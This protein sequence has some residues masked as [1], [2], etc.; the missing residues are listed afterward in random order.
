[1]GIGCQQS[2]YLVREKLPPKIVQEENP[3]DKYALLVCALSDCNTKYNSAIDLIDRDCDSLALFRMYEVLINNGFPD[4]YIFVLYSS[5]GRTPNFS[6]GNSPAAK[7][8]EEKQFRGQYDN[9]A[10]ERNIESVLEG[11]KERVDENDKVVFYLA[12][13]GNCHGT[14]S[15]EDEWIFPYEFQEYVNGWKSNSNWF[16]ITNC[17]GGTTLD[18]TEVDNVCLYAATQSDTLGW[19]DIHWCGG[20]K[21]MQNKVDM[22][23]DT[24]QDGIVDY[25]EAFNAVKKKA[26]IYWE[27]YLKG[28]IDN[29][30]NK[31][32]DWTSD[33]IDLQPK[34]KVGKNFKKAPL[35]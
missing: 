3:V 24:N 1:M 5:E 8:M 9:T 21:F 7:R 23:N 15:L 33:D 13:H 2:V 10:S 35:N 28:Y 31:K 12:A 34:I 22:Q 20:V 4:E 26:K 30:Y 32:S 19:I 18:L 14:I 27:T 16:I 6:A 29:E 11:F 17:Y 25:E